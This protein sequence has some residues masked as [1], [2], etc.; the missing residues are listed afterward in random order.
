[1]HTIPSAAVR[2]GAEACP[3]SNH[4][5]AQL[6]ELPPPWLASQQQILNNTLTTMPNLAVCAQGTVYNYSWK[7]P[8]STGHLGLQTN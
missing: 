4:P 8:C 3:N 5:T 7:P 1:M 2:M 6:A